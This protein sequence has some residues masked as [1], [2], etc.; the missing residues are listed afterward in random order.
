VNNKT[1][2]A[3]LAAAKA[4][5]ALRME[6]FRLDPRAALPTRAHSTDVGWDIRAHILSESGREITTAIHQKGVTA[7][8]TGLVVKPPPGFFVQVCS[9]SGLAKHGLF[10]ANAPGIVDPS[11][12][13]EII[14][15]LFNGSYETKYVSHGNR[16]AQLVLT[17]IV[18]A[19]VVELKERPTSTER[20]D[21]GF[22]SSGD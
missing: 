13:G 1:P 11:Y 19:Q 22:G 5:L 8:P 20:G 15:L 14:V 6:I 4:A 7:I 10:V 3:D 21:A 2:S 17:P 18:P 16:I 9:R 12:T